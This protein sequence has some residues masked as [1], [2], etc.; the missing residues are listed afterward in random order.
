M[1]KLFTLFLVTLSVFIFAAEPS[2]YYNNAVGKA[3]AALRTSL[4]TIIAEGHSVTSYNGLWTAYGS[5]DINP[6]TGKIWDMYSNCSFTWRTDQN[7]GTTGA[8]CLNY[9]REHSI[10]QSWFGEASPMVS[11]AFHVYPTDSKVNG[12]R[13]SYPFGE[14]GSATNTTGNGSKLG[15]SSF[16]GYSGTVFEPINEY[17]GDF[18]RTYFYMATRYSGACENWSG[19]VFSSSF[20]GLSA[21]AKDIFL[22]WHR[23]DPVSIKEK[24]RNNTVESVQHN[25]NPFIDHPE[26]AEFIWGTRKGEPWSLVSAIDK[27]KIAFSV[28][29][30]PVQNELTI[31]SDESNLA[32]S[33]YNL[34]GQ[35]IK[36]DQLSISKTI[37]LEQLN[38]GMYLLQLKSGNRK[39]IQKFIVSK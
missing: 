1:K 16:S 37:S 3:D 10:P 8:E 13:G 12:I 14:V 38:N 7:S 2:G 20:S 18:A 29:P 39:S 21:Y 25:R 19:G 22:K 33:I 5:T 32:Y 27:V 6:S 24:N 30:N 11:D 36:E 31:N 35:L 4:K 9:N 34:S 23:Q 28:S 17:K 15:S 26:L